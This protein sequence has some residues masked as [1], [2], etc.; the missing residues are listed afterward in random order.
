[1]DPV[2]S[3]IKKP[4][5]KW[6]LMKEIYHEK[7]NGRFVIFSAYDETFHHIKNILNLD[8]LEIKGKMETRDRVIDIFKNEP[9]KQ[10]LFLNSIDNG[11]GLNLQEATDIILFHEMSE[12]ME[13]QIIGRCQRIGRTQPLTVH[14]FRISS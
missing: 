10:I 11:A 4:L 13:T 6:E 8:I 12:A 1:M 5:S 2:Q 3:S 14:H 9:D 7:E